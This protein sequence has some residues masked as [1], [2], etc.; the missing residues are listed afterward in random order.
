MAKIEKK[1]F[2]L[3]DTYGLTVYDNADQGLMVLFAI[4]VDEIREH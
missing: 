4:L 3:H 2:H 1:S